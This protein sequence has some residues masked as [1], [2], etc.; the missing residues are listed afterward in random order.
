VWAYFQV[1]VKKFFYEIFAAQGFCYQVFVMKHL[2]PKVFV[3]K[4]FLSINF[5]AAASPG[6]PCWQF[7][8]CRLQ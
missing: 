6:W 7:L 8:H 4:I 2:S 5:A 3:I 1:F